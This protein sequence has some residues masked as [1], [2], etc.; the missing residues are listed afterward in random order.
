MPN[1]FASSFH[2]PLF[3]ALNWRHAFF[4]II[5]INNPKKHNFMHKVYY[6]MAGFVNKMCG[7]V[8]TRD[9]GLGS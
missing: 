1:Y 5:C 3:R 9:Q 8:G 6:L 4:N 2:S 7:G